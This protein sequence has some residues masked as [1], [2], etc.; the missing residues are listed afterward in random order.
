[1]S[2]HDRICL[3]FWAKLCSLLMLA[4][5]GTNTH[6]LV[7][8]TSAQPTTKVTIF[9]DRKIGTF[10]KKCFSIKYNLHFKWSL[11]YAT[12]CNWLKL[13]GITMKPLITNKFIEKGSMNV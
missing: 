3:Y 4:N 10:R 1:M 12:D 5:L 8:N 6:S 13:C 2:V 7:V 11:M 9:L